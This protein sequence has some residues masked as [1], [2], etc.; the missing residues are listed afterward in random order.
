MSKPAEPIQAALLTACKPVVDHDYDRDRDH[1]H[2][3]HIGATWTQV[4]AFSATVVASFVWLSVE[5]EDC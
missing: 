3:D 4:N 1:D 5:E 2:V